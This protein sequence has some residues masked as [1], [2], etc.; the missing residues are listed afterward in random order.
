MPRNI[1]ILRAVQELHNKRNLKL[2]L[3]NK[4]KRH[5]THATLEWDQLMYGILHYNMHIPWEELG[6]SPAITQ[7]HI[8]T[9]SPWECCCCLW[10]GV[11][12][13]LGILSNKLTTSDV[14]KECWLEIC[15][16]SFRWLNTLFRTVQA[17]SLQMVCMHKLKIKNCKD[18]Y[19]SEKSYLSIKYFYF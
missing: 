10:P 5:S 3:F 14:Y 7:N 9:P 18:S 11:Q 6:D 13:F 17:L 1:A 4:F 8:Q 2:L 15:D 12:S 19:L 16:S